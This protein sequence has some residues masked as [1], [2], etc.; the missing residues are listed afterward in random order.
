MK[1][2]YF[3]TFALAFASIGL[4]AQTTVW[5][6]EGAPAK[7]EVVE[8][9]RDG[10]YPDATVKTV[11][12]VPASAD[13][14]IDIDTAVVKH[15]VLGDNTPNGGVIIIKD[16]GVLTTDTLG[17]WSTV[18]YDEAAELIIEAGGVVNSGHRFHVGLVEPK[19]PAEAI[20]EVAGTLNVKNIFS[21]N[22]GGFADWTAEAYITTGGVINTPNFLIGDGG[23][24]DVT[25]GMLI[26]GRDMKDALLGY[27]TAGKLTAEGGTEEPTIEWQITGTGEEADTA[28]VVK[29]STTVGV[30]NNKVA[31]QASIGVY[32]NPARDVVYFNEG[33]VSNVQV[34]SIT[35]EV[36]LRRSNV[37]QLNIENLKPGYYIIKSEA[38]R[39]TY[40]DKLL[41]K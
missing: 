36:V 21:V 25:G 15:L 1:N 7:W 19:G 39:R 12:N 4:F 40:I 29:S 9:W 14:L 34:Y 8:N 18:G 33:V 38:N 35:G 17:P 10:L 11:F 24:L 16:G 28:T 27:V 41:V 20:L 2:K 26:I 32:P 22:P 30:F 5:I 37:S 13:C 31:N 3:L 6:A 23:L